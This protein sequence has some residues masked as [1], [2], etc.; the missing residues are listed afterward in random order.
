MNLAN[1]EIHPF[2]YRVPKID[3]PTSLVFDCDPGEGANVLTC[4]RATLMLRNMLDD[5]VLQSL[6]TSQA[7]RV[8]RSMCLSIPRLLTKL[9]SHWLKE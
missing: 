3:R 9:R 7:R 5:L 8:C 2:L 4:A 6:P 1:L